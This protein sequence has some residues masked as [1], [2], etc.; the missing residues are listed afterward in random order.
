MTAHVR[1]VKVY[2]FCQVELNSEDAK[3]IKKLDNYRLRFTEE[4]RPL[5]RGNKRTYCR[6]G[7]K[8]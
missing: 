8:T 2:A 7:N 6:I 1:F 3:N 4:I 5:Q